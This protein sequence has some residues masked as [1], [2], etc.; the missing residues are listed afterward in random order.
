MPKTKTQKIGIMLSTSWKQI[1][2]KVSAL[3]MS[4]LSAS[5]LSTTARA[6]HKVWDVE[7]VQ[8]VPCAVFLQLRLSRMSIAEDSRV[9]RRISTMWMLFIFLTG[10][11]CAKC[12]NCVQTV[13]FLPLDTQTTHMNGHMVLNSNQRLLEPQGIHYMSCCRESKS[14]SARLALK[15]LWVATILTSRLQEVTPYP[16]SAQRDC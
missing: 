13:G 5:C 14:H 7:V 11:G 15:L 10:R 1:V 16:C 3:S 9:E 12:P 6:M 2:C 4:K 8:N